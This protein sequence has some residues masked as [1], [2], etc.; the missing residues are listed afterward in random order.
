MSYHRFLIVVWCAVGVLLLSLRPG[1]AAP[2]S[3]EIA[4]AWHVTIPST[5]FDPSAAP[6]GITPFGVL[7]AIHD[8][9]VRPLP[10]AKMGASL[11]ESWRVSSDGLSYEFN[12]RRGLKFHNGDPVTTEDVKFSFERYKGVG[13]SELQARVRQV[14]IVNPLTVR[15]HLKEPWPDFMTFYGT[16]TTAAGLVVPKKYVTEVGDEG[17]RKK[18]IGAGPYRFVSY[19]PGDTLVLEANPGYWR[20]VP[21][22][23]RLVM[24]SIPEGTTRAAMLKRGEADI[25]YALEGAEVETVTRDPRLRVGASQYTSVSW[26][27]FADQWQPRSAWHDRRVRLAANLALN[28]KAIGGAACPGSCGPAGTIIPR[29]M[30][31][32]LRVPPPS[33]DPQKAKQL[34]QEAGYPNGFDAGDLAVI[35]S[36]ST[37]AAADAVTKDLNAVGIR[38]NLRRM[39]RAAFFAAWREKKLSG[40][41]LAAAG[42]PGNAANRIQ[43][44]VY[45]KGGFAYGGYPDTDDLFEQQARERDALKRQALLSK[46]QQVTIDRAMFAPLLEHP[47]LV[48]VGPR[49][50]ALSWIHDSPFPAYEDLIVGVEGVPCSCD[51]NCGSNCC[52]KCMTIPIL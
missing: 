9:L 4:I 12:L 40:L 28:R 24:K 25:A 43:T 18:P 5:W 7:Y 39:E 41:F 46:I 49:V 13:A 8:A 44:Y 35:G 37:V 50:N 11:A 29:A 38:V 27:E 6:A 21:F 17:F 3:G 26:L 42:T 45:S 14:E 10:G 36:S 20:R 30:D 15:F 52:V 1:W 51:K 22:V 47:L 16:P 23:N 19:Q 31:G 33:Y 2:P 34:L 32:A 48:G